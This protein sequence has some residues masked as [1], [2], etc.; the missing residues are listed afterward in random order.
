MHSHT[1]V[2][3]FPLPS[4]Q[5]SAVGTT[6]GA[7][8]ITA[9]SMCSQFCLPSQLRPCSRMRQVVLPPGGCSSKSPGGH[10]QSFLLAG[11]WPHIKGECGNT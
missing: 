6:L 3:L 9:P 1:L 11:C 10:E 8:Q 7:V 4:S 2:S 5:L